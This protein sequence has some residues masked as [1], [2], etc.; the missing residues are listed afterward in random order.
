MT[1]V[2]VIAHILGFLTSLDALMRTRTSQ[3]AIAWIACLNTLPVLSVPAY[4]VFGRTKFQGYVSLR[5]DLHE[6]HEPKMQ[7]VRE[8][9]AP[10]VVEFGSEAGGAAVGV[11]L[12]ELP[13][14]GGNEVELLIDGEATFASILAGIDAATEYVLLQF[15]IVRD[16]D[17]GRE[18]RD[19]LI[20]RSRAGVRVYFLHDEV[21]SHRLPGRYGA[22]LSAGGVQFRAFHSTRGSGNRFQLNFRNHRKIVVVDGRVGWVGGHNIGDEYVGRDSGAAKWRDTH[23]RVEGP[24]ALELQLSFVEDWRWATE[25]FLDLPWTP[26]AAEDGAATVLVLPSGPADRLETASLMYQQAIQSARSRVWIASPYFVP[27]E[28]VMA[29]LHLARLRGV[30]VRV[31]IPDRADSALSKFAPY[32][33]VGALLESGVFVH[34]YLPGF[35]HQKVILV[36]DRLAGIGTANLDNRSFR[37]NFEVTA[38]VADAAFAAEVADMLEAD[39]A[40]SRP[41]TLDEVRSRRWWSRALSRAAYLAAPIQ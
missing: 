35:M 33:F 34:R 32:A 12:A 8:H 16:D 9:V 30:E 37:L 4:W 2:L 5:R 18:I 24:A 25:E 20:A 14:L 41:M 28:G 36:D 29:S 13:F 40:H 31:I 7:R 17:L 15:Y 21:G 23:M 19:H 6:S 10:F 22:A 26:R 11:G 39:I 38:L 3:G 27:D 1:I